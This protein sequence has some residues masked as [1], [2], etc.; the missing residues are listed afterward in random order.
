MKYN[1]LMSNDPYYLRTLSRG[2][3]TS[4]ELYFQLQR[5]VRSVKED[6]IREMEEK[7]NTKSTNQGYYP[8]IGT[9]FIKLIPG[10]TPRP[11]VTDERSRLSHMVSP[12]WV[13][14]YDLLEGTGDW[15]RWLEDVK[16]EKIHVV[17]CPEFGT[18]PNNHFYLKH[19]GLLKDDKV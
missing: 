12:G 7:L 16:E 5:L 10:E 17:W 15:P 4:E 9:V 14:F 1:D 6:T 8:E 13:C 11:F 18:I 2:S 3:L 19:H